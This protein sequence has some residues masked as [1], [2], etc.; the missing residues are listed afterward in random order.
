MGR[1][2]LLDAETR[3]RTLRELE[4]EDWGGPGFASHL[5]TECHRLRRVPLGAF[6]PEDLR[7][8]IGQEIG[9]R[10]LVPLALERLLVEPWVSG[11]LYAGDVLQAVL[12]V[13]PSFW[14]AHPTLTTE[15]TC[16]ATRALEEYSSSRGRRPER[17]DE[18]VVSLLQCWLA[19]PVQPHAR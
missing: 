14:E 2:L 15:L 16:A 8:L 19:C 6:R 18:E 1:D 7:I 5:V 17:Y 13:R 3:R 4:G 10:F 12:Q 11:D 9:L